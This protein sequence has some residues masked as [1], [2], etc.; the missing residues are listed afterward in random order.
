VWGETAPPIRAGNML[1]FIAASNGGR[2]LSFSYSKV[3]GAG[4]LNF[5]AYELSD[6]PTGEEPE[7][8]PGKSQE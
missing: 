3:I 8:S 2:Q 6:S 1:G 7:R 5:R 4:T